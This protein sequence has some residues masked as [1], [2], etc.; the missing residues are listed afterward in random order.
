MA[1]QGFRSNTGARAGKA[2]ATDARSRIF[3]GLSSQ[4]Q[5]KTKSGLPGILLFQRGSTILSS[6]RSGPPHRRK[7]VANIVLSIDVPGPRTK[8]LLRQ[9]RLFLVVCADPSDV[10]L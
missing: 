5:R 4:D 3:R 2:L 1:K 10:I 8:P 6:A 9:W 7:L